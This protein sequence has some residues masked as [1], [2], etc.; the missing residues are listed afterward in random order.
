[1]AFP[2]EY[3]GYRCA[4][5]DEGVDYEVVFRRRRLAL[6]RMFVREEFEPFPGKAGHDGW[7]L[8]VA[9]RVQGMVTPP[10]E[11]WLKEVTR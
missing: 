1:M 3:E 6:M 10:G 2:L 8:L 7:M 9:V 11:E 4:E 5:E